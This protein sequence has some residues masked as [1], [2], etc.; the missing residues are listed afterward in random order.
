MKNIIQVAIDS[1][2]AAGAGTQA[3]LIAKHYKLFHL[4]TGKIY[5]FLG[6]LKI[7]YKNKFNYTLINQKMK[8]IKIHNLNDKS[9]LSNKVAMEASIIA[10]DPKIRKIVHN[11][12]I[13]CAYNPPKKFNGSILDGRDIT[14][15][16]MKDAM[17]KFFITAEVKTR[18]FRRFKELKS[19]KR[20]I[21]Y[22]DVLKSIKKRDKN[23]YNRKYSPLKKTKDSILINTTN[24]T[25]K[26]CF[27][28]IKKIMDKKL[29]I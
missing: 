18:A 23:D 15:V 29:K 5:R 24:L 7:K 27:L 16:I 21:S 17:F 26:A 22:N 6:K 11:F 10:K 4:D 25:K 28:K 20:K 13:K 1:P 3:K 19:L 14:S 12:Q 8:K 2:A 9:L